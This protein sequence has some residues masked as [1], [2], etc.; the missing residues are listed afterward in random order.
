VVRDFF[1]HHA[2]RIAHDLMP[3]LPEVETVVRALREP[4]VGRTITGVRT[5]WG[6]HIAVPSVDELKARLIGEKVVAINRRAK[7]LVFALNGADTLLMHLKMS[8]HL[9]V[10]PADSPQHKHVRTVFELDNGKEL[11][12][13]DMRKFGKVYLVADKDEI[14]GHLG[15]EPLED[16]FTVAVLKERLKGRTRAMK[17]LL[18]DQTF[19][20]GVGN[21]YADES[22]FYAKI[23]PLRQADS[24]T[25]EEVGLLYAGIQHVLQEGI[26]RE[27][28]SIDTYIKPDG[29]KGDMQNAVNVFRRTGQ[30]CYRCGQLID[31]IIVG[32][33]STHYC[34]GCQK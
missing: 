1:T 28:A 31:R 5:Y 33:R 20:A 22:L 21:I 14:L 27:G 3:E 12:F 26:K 25:E 32:G 9:S 11:R 13:K 23:H 6:K 18:L 24:L 15:P 30:S 17:P 10:E 29:E 8:G 2:P 19:I 7:Y 4:V 34:V 16:E